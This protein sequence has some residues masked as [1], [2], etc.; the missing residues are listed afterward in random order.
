MLHLFLFSPPFL[1][2]DQTLNVSNLLTLRD[3]SVKH[4]L[5]VGLG[6][7][8]RQSSIRCGFDFR[9]IVYGVVQAVRGSDPDPTVSHDGGLSLQR[10]RAGRETVQME[11]D[12]CS[13]SVKSISKVLAGVKKPGKYIPLHTDQL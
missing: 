8:Q 5:I 13:V 9:V 3:L 12:I 1:R 10:L 7:H 6:I 2:M 4:A 11:V